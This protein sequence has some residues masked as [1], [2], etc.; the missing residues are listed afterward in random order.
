METIQFKINPQVDM[1]QDRI[2]WADIYYRLKQNIVVISQYRL[3][4]NWI[5]MH[6]V[7]DAERQRTT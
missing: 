4:S 6:K 1:R 7:L 3:I 2:D 5:N